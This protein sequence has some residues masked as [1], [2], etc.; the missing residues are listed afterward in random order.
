MSNE[1]INLIKNYLNNF[2]I[3]TT[4]NVFKKYVSFSGIVDKNNSIYITYLPDE[5]SK[6]V[7]DT[8]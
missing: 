6:N 8:A 7:I 4:P 1:N 5:N 3:E 2:T